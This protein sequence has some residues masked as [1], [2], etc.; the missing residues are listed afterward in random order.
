M[1]I[2]MADVDYGIDGGWLGIFDG[3]IVWVM[4]DGTMINRFEGEGTRR[5]QRV[6]HYIRGLR[7]GMQV[8]DRAPHNDRSA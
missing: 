5:E 8:F 6:A 2:N 3:V 1:S 4:N 7:G